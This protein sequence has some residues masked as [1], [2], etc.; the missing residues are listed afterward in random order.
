MMT[1]QVTAERGVVTPGVTRVFVALRIF[2]GL[3]WLSNA[4]A[5]VFGMNTFH[6]GPVSFNLVD[7]NTAHAILR[8]GSTST[9]IAPLRAF[10]SDVVLPNWAFFQVFL[11]IAELAVAIG[12]LF[13][14]ATRLAALGGLLL[15]FPIWIMLMNTDQYLWTYPLD[16]FPLVLL[17]LVPAGRTVGVDGK[18]LTPIFGERWPF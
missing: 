9:G 13:G 6:W 5:K 12:L 2:F 8:Q 15:L 4:L 10:Y 17:A 11:T 18:F 16:L 1:A 7:R 3:N 14:I